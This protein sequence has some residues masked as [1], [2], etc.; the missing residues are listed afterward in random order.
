MRFCCVSLVLG[1]LL[2]TSATAQVTPFAIE[3]VDA[4]TGRGVP[5]VELRTVNG[6]RLFTDSAGLVAF[7]EPGLMD[8]DVFFHVSSHGYEFP[9]DGFG[10]R[11]KA[12]HTTPGGQA[13]LQVHRLNI[14]QRLYRITGQGIYRDSLRLGRSVPIEQ[15]A[16]NGRVLGQDSTQ[17]VVYRDRI[18]WLWGDTQRESY[19]LGLFKTSG[20]TSELPGR[21]G[22]D[23]SV[24]V[25]LHYFVDEKGFSRPMAPLEGEGL[26]WL[27]ALMVLPD[28]TGRQRMIAHYSRMK[29]LEQRLEHGLVVFDDAQQTF[30]KLVKFPDD[31]AAYPRGHALSVTVDGQ[32]YIYFA[33]PYPLIRV[34]ARWADVQNPTRYEAFTCVAPGQAY[35]GKNTRLDRDEH[36]RLC[37]SWKANAAYMDAMRQRELIQAGAM[38]ADEAWLNTRDVESGE[39]VLLH[40]GSVRWN[41]Y[42]QAWVMIAVQ[43]EGSSMLGEVWFAQANQPEGPWPWARKVVSHDRYSFYNPVHHAFFD[44]EGG[45][46]IYF[47][48]TYSAAFSG[49]PAPTPRYDYNQIMYRLDLADPRLNP[50]ATQPQ[51]DANR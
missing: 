25:N 12:L 15:P 34:P 8:R 21:G 33:S 16:L 10:F 13:R 14:A 37:W 7:D 18:Y 17:A 35:E 44:Q 47:E 22:L 48:G 51:H 31:A 24:G 32:P 50:P 46:V 4:Q 42:R 39:P 2:A 41:A 26:I 9:A 45:R 36:G 30:R 28:E 1:W 19:P 5:M 27:D 11:G 23:P 29:S 20:A 6:I 38:S 40:S 3:V 49:A 43:I